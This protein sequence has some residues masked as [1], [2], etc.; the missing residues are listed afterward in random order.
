MSTEINKI[1]LAEYS[2]CI[3]LRNLAE[4]AQFGTS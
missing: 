3:F 4:I 1:L 2:L